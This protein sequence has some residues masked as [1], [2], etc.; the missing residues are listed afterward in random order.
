MTRSTREKKPGALVIS[1]DLEL[2]WGVRDKSA[3]DGAYQEN[4]RGARRAAEAMLE[5]FRRYGIAATW[6]TVGLLFARD[7]EELEALRPTLRPSYQNRSLDPY[8]ET[9]GQTEDEDPL[10]FA[11]S[12]ID[13]IAR[14]PGQEIGTHTFS[15]YY[16]L[17]PGQDRE[18]FRVDM[19]AAVRVADERGVS[20]RS[21]VFPRNQLNPDYLDILRALGI[22]AYRGNQTGFMYVP[23]GKGYNAPRMR[24]GRL[25][26][27]YVNLSGR[28]FTPWCEFEA[29]KTPINI[30]ANIFLRPYRPAL[31]FPEPL[32]LHRI[33]RAMARAAREEG[34]FHMWWHPHNFGTYLRENLEFLERILH[35]HEVL[36]RRYGMLSLSM[37]GVSSLLLDSEKRADI[38][39][40][41]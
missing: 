13:T 22:R 2:H 3:V 6:A 28:P 5:L 21:C 33:M 19:E 35:H 12:L 29:S 27:T 14:T 36:R 17:E 9:P 8:L 31:A 15:H 26:D 18:T 37:D 39:E 25:A 10:H 16:C 1:L 23:K 38:A 40:S 34:I 41:W 32:R 4:L 20:L 11:S 7:R 30:P 24:L